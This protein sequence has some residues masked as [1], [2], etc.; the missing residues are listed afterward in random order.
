MGESCT[1]GWDA[2]SSKASLT[3]ELQARNQRARSREG[4]GSGPYHYIGGSA[5]L[6]CTRNPHCHSCWVVWRQ[7]TRFKPLEYASTPA[8][9]PTLGV[10]D[11]VAAASLTAT[12]QLAQA[13]D[14]AG[15]TLLLGERASLFTEAQAS[16]GH[17]RKVVASRRQCLGMY[18]GSALRKKEEHYERCA[19]VHDEGSHAVAILDHVLCAAVDPKGVALLC[20]GGWVNAFLHVVELHLDDGTADGKLVH[21]AFIFAA[22][23]IYEETEVRIVY[24]DERRKSYAGVRRARGYTPKQRD[25][26][27][28]DDFNA[29]EVASLP[30][31]VWDA[32]EP[33]ALALALRYGGVE[34]Y[35]DLVED[36]NVTREPGVPPPPAAAV[37]RRYDAANVA[38]TMR[39]TAADRIRRAEQR[40]AR[41][42]AMQPPRPIEAEELESSRSRHVTTTEEGDAV[43]FA[44]QQCGRPDVTGAPTLRLAR[45]AEHNYADPRVERSAVGGALR[46]EG[47]L[48]TLL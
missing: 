24:D 29:A 47:F 7:G 4:Q 43:N 42:L 36:R 18:V 20:E 33:S 39:T 34:D 22:E 32:F 17:P 25:P 19:R 11:H 2:P 38:A 48:V 16:F 10:P 37:V 44:C 45:C 15:R 13:A 21:A 31:S 14:G 23:E 30:D 6:A 12:F 27:G 46:S 28:P 3:S 35:G 1:Y 5:P 41:R 26:R 40:N 9:E 8:A